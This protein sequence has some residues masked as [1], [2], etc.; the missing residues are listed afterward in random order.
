MSATPAAFMVTDEDLESAGAPSYDAIEVPGDYEATLTAVE[1]YDKRDK[2]GSHGWI[3]TYRIMG[4]PFKMWVAHSPASRW[5]LIEVVHAHAPG[6][7]D[8]RDADGASKPVNPDAF[9]G[10]TVGAH[11]VLDSELDTPRRVIDYVF[12][13]EEPE[14]TAD[15]VPLL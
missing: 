15:D 2:G 10:S 4:L 13:M 8:V 3:F 6:F 7:F 12:S 5:K 14:P 11:V 9:V 1:D